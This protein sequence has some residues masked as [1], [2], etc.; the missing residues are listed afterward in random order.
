MVKNNPFEQVNAQAG[1]FLMVEVVIDDNRQTV[2]FLKEE[3]QYIKKYPNKLNI[4]LRLGMK[5]VNNVMVVPVMMLVN[6]DY[7]MLY[8]SF[9]NFHAEGFDG[10]LELLE[11]QNDILLVFFNETNE[12]VRQ[13][14]FTN[15]IKEDIQEIN[16]RLKSS[17]K[18]S[19]LGFDIA[20]EEMYKMFPSPMKLWSS[21]KPIK[22]IYE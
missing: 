13:V 17:T 14:K 21:L 8:E 11:N 4:E 3:T 19:M 9:Y 5:K 6:N 22:P 20:K 18:W 12:M 2:L 15:N 10:I 1:S 7:D 16:M